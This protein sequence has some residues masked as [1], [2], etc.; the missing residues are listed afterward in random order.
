M[1]TR[2]IKTKKQERTRH[3]R[4]IHTR[5][6]LELEKELKRFAE[7]LRVPVSNLIRTI[8]EDALAVAEQASPR[9]ETELRS[10]TAQLA[11]GRDSL[12]RQLARRI[13]RRL[14]RR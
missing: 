11:R 3:E 1:V 2:K 7:N 10:R 9:V 4:V 8:L 12:R 6:P 14:A 13:P 5:V